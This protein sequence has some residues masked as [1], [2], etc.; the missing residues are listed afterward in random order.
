M[1]EPRIGSARARTQSEQ[2]RLGGE[3]FIWI[4]PVNLL[5]GECDLDNPGNQKIIVDNPH[6]AEGR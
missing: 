2:V 5:G 6:I 3:T 4:V 1:S